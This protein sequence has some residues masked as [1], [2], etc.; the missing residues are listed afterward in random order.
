MP[1][2]MR[3]PA[4]VADRYKKLA[5]ETGRSMSFYYKKALTESIDDLEYEYGLLKQ[6]EDYHAGRLETYSLDE[7]RAHLDLDD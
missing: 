4:D 5:A 3:V 6:V 1:T 2:T 7:V